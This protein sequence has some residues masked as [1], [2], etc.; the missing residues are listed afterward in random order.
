MA[1]NYYQGSQKR[2][3][4]LLIILFVLVIVALFIFGWNFFKL[5]ESTI[6]SMSYFR[7]KNIEI[8]FDVFKNPFLQELQPFEDISYPEEIKIGRESPFLPY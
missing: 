6:P 8:N 7:P 2:L 3:R 5:P 1:I 4:Y